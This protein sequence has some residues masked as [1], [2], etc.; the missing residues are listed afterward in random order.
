M[1]GCARG[2]RARCSSGG[3]VTGA[4]AGAGTG[5]GTGAGAGATGGEVRN[6]P[7]FSRFAYVFGSAG[8]CDTEHH[9]IC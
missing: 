7:D 3:A 6:P 5:A 9:V 4:G 1:G 2:G 8:V